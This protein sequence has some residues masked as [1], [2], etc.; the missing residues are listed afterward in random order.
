MRKP[1]LL[2]LCVSLLATPAWAQTAADTAPEKILIVGQRPGPGL[3]KVSKDDHVLWI[4]GTYAPLPVKMV[5]RSAQVET[6]LAQSQE[7]LG[8][9]GVS[10]GVGFSQAFNLITALPFAL[11]ARKNPDGA[12]LRDVVPPDVYARWSVLKQKYMSDD[13]GVERE[14]PIFAAPALFD[15]AMAQ[16]G[17]GKDSDVISTIKQ[18]AKKNNVKYTPTEITLQ[19]D[20][21]RGALRDFKKSPMAD[22]EC[23]TKTIDRLEVDLDAMRARANAWAIGDVDIMRKLSYPDQATACNSAVF[24]SP[25]MKSLP[26]AA[27]LP[28]RMRDVWLAA[29]EKSLAA[30]KS[31]FALLQMSRILESDGVIAALQARGYAV[32]QPD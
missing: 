15:K 31:T 12:L 13:D 21:P 22:L 8:L 9:P 20:N 2:T 26:G 32:E 30:N 4:F 29:A 7:M 10:V 23:F 3:W 19:L 1:L 18:I 27:T 25:V 24:N 5:W 28:Q 6:V 11:G 14:R 16:A 17:L